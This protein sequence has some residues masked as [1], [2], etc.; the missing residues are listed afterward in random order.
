[1]RVRVVRWYQQPR[2]LLR[3]DD[4]FRRKARRAF[5]VS[6]LLVLTRLPFLLAVGVSRPW[7]DPFA[8]HLWDEVPATQ[9]LPE[10]PVLRGAVVVRRVTARG[11]GITLHFY[12]GGEAY[13]VRT[14]DGLGL[15][16]AGWSWNPRWNFDDW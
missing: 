11:D 7:L 2:V 5:V 15:R 3:L 12:G 10:G 9:P 16:L 1:V 14:N 4:P 13:Y 8:F 6:T